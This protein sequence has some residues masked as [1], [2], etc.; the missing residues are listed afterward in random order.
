MIPGNT[1]NMLHS[2]FDCRKQ[3]SVTQAPTLCDILKSF[4][5]FRILNA[6]VMKQKNI[7]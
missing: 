7:R 1:L 3:V 6:N 5:S 2:G 4:Q